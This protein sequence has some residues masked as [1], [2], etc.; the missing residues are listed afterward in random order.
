[1][2]AAW[3]YSIRVLLALAGCYIALL[4]VFVFF[5]S[6]TQ[7]IPFDIPGWKHTRYAPGFS[8]D[9]F[10]NVQRG[11]SIQQVLLALGEPVSKLE[12]WPP[13][14]SRYSG[15]GVSFLT[16]VGDFK[17][18]VVTEIRDPRG[19]LDDRFYVGMPKE[20]LGQILGRPDSFESEGSP[21]W[22]KWWYSDSPS[23][24]NHWGHELLV[25]ITTN[26]VLDKVRYFHT[27]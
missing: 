2:E 3:G 12:G 9:A 25:N 8:L 24:A 15:L 14:R 17:T 4:F 18:Y 26:Q 22:Q 27:K 7:H 1:M 11:D 23:N 20:D 13:S 21:T 5:G 6:I 19:V 10:E 16:A